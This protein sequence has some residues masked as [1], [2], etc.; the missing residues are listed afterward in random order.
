MP[1][2]S[3]PAESGLAAV[4][5]P[6]TSP[7]LT[8]GIPGGLL[9]QA[10]KH[11]RSIGTVNI[12]VAG[13]TGV[14]KSTLVNAV[15]GRTAAPTA[16]GKPV[17]QHAK[18]YGSDALPLRLVD[19]R[20]LEAKEYGLTLRAIRSE[21]EHSRAERSERDQIHLAWVCIAAP[22]S[23]V[24]D[25]EVD[26]IR[27]LNLHDIPVIVVLTKD[28]GEEENEE[29]DGGFAGTVAQILAGRRAEVSGIIRVRALAHARH[30]AAGLDSLFAATFAALPEAHRTAFAAAQ[31][32]SRGQ[33]LSRAAG[34]VNAA[35]GAAAVASMVPV[36]SAAV[37]ALAVIQGTML[38]GIGRAFG[39][40]PGWR[41]VLH[42]VSV[43]L[44]CMATT[45]AGGWAV[46]GALEVIPGPDAV[47]GAVLNGI[48][49]GSVTWLLGQATLRSLQAFLAAEGRLPRADETV[50][51]L[52]VKPK[53][54]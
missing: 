44:G 52:L 13:Q 32:V 35:A 3:G 4:S 43:L 38:A 50:P 29:S 39:F 24:Q 5:K 30:P 21:I 19:T 48:I 33:S 26:V 6:H 31:K 7:A 18:W 11:L 40:A 14:G 17:T 36:L 20:G 51:L 23:R 1:A 15:L 28:D 34:Y 49:A 2:E 27:V 8:L 37:V 25:C 16:R 12:L 53:A 41:Q 9:Q 10:A 47:T 46:A 42:L 45:V 54:S 22:S